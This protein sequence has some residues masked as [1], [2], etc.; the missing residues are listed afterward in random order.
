MKKINISINNLKFDG[1][2]NDTK[3]AERIYEALPIKAK[4]NFWGNEIYF[5]IP[6]KM[7]NEKPTEELEV[8][9]L[10]YWPEGNAFCIFFGRTPASSNGEPKPI[11][12]VTVIGK[13]KE[14]TEELKKLKEAEV[15]IA[16]S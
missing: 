13:I 12:P 10:A 8:G 16:K 7:E 5:D 11:G 9:E 2:L 4:G 14:D 6:L 1:E 3:T 15:E